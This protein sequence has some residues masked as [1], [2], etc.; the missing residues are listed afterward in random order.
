MS[1]VRKMEILAVI[2]RGETWIGTVRGKRLEIW[3]D[4]HG[5]VQVWREQRGRYA[6]YSADTVTQALEAA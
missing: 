4:Q 2:R 6:S 5:M 1:A 3:L